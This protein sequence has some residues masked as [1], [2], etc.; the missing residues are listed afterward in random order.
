MR[1]P[2]LFGRR[3]RSYGL[4]GGSAGRG[5]RS[6]GAA[7]MVGPWD[8]I[9]AP[10]LLSVA[11][12]V[13]LAM[14]FQP[15]GFY[16][17]EPVSPFIL[18]FAWPL[19]R[20]SYFSPIVLAALG[21]FLDYFWGGP[22]GFWTIGLMLVYGAMALARTFMVGQDWIVVFGVFISTELLFFAL[23]VVLTIV[24]T[25][26]VPRLWGVAEQFIATGLLFP[27]VL[28]L[29]ETYLHADVRFQ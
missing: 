8:W 11:L 2:D 1:L 9:L 12:T 23:C 7:K 15:F 13:V 10:A 25:G 26:S 24:D 5:V 19:I 3:K 22:I 4:S 18:A 27:F 20:P 29:L 16:L 28:Y 17:P 6:G 14:S 21:F